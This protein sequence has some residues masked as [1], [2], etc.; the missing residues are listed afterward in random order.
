MPRGREAAPD[1]V[2][3]LVEDALA[4]RGGVLVVAGAAGSGK[5]ALVRAAEERAAP[6]MQLLRCRGGETL[7]AVPFAGARALLAPVL[8]LR[9]RI[10]HAQ[11]RALGVALAADPP[12]PYDLSAVPAAVRSLLAVVAEQGP[13]LAAIDD[14]HW[15]DEPSLHAVLALAHAPAPAGVAVLLA[16]REDPRLGRRLAGLETLR[17]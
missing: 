1:R 13:V 4:G 9:K 12:G 2:A 11:A 15:L 14:L 16:A 7:R 5:T 10:P 6:R 8:G 17:L 3:G